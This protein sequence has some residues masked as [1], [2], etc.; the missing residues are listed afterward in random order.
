M[1]SRTILWH[2]REVGIPIAGAQHYKPHN[3]VASRNVSRRKV[4]DV[5]CKMR[6][7]HV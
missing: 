7:T 2:R 4:L 6:E 3:Q 5:A 1:G